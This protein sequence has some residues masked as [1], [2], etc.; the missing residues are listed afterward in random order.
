[1]FEPQIKKISESSISSG[2]FGAWRNAFAYNA[3]YGKA[4]ES[5]LRRQKVGDAR[6]VMTTRAAGTLSPR[7][8]QSRP[9]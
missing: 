8:N 7:Q 3:K 9:F 2:W 4:L 1:M 6:W 5:P